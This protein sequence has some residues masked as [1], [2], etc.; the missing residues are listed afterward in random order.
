MAWS[1]STS[2]LSIN[3]LALCD[4][5]LAFLAGPMPQHR[6][7]DIRC[8]GGLLADKV[9]QGR[10][11]VGSVRAKWAALL[12]GIR[13]ASICNTGAFHRGSFRSADEAAA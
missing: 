9:N 3:K 12:N 2:R 11:V 8:V 4:Q 1:A 7:G 13:P 10:T 6:Y 5:L